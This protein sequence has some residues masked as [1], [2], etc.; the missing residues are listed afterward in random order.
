MSAI[1]RNEANPSRHPVALVEDHQDIREQ[2]AAIVDSSD[3][4]TCVCACASA[5]EALRKIPAARPEVILMDVFLPKMS[6]IE[7]TARLKEIMPDAKILIVT[8]SD[9]EELVF[10]ALEAG[11]DGYLLKHAS[12]ADVIQALEDVLHGGMPMTSG[13]ARKVAEFFHKKGQERRQ[14]VRLSQRETEVL[15]LIA[16]GYVNK[17]I[18]DK[19]S[20]TVQTVRSYLKTIYEKLHVHSRAEAVL[21]Y[22]KQPGK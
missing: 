8:A 10:H 9:D 2:W 20:L 17:E 11:A 22:M 13:V 1:S 7:C 15:E 18:A 6:G 4:F 14:L 19:L 21:K 12:P 16:A 3:E 5:E